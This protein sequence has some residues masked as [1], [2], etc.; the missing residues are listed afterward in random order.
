MIKAFEDLV[1]HSG[2]V[3]MYKMKRSELDPALAVS[4][5]TKEKR[6]RAY[7]DVAEYLT[8]EGKLRKVRS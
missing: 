3:V 6:D 7:Q 1:F 5:Q 4:L 2:E 8:M